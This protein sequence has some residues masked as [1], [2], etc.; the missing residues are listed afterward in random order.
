MGRLAGD[1][2][3]PASGVSDTRRKMGGGMRKY[4]FFF[5]C[6]SRFI[7]SFL[8]SWARVFSSS[9]II[10]TTY[11]PVADFKKVTVICTL[12]Q[13][14]TGPVIQNLRSSMEMRPPGEVVNFVKA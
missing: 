14:Y 8:K 9:F 10:Y 3:G 7:L 2:R 11:T 4:P 5:Q 13:F 12:G 6:T 1:T